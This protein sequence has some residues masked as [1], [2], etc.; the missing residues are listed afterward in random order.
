MGVTEELMIFVGDRL[1]EASQARVSVLDA[2]FQSGDAVWEGMRVYNGT[3]LKLDRHLSRLESSAR[4]LRIGLPYDRAGL[5]AAVYDTL[6]ANDFV[7]DTH[8]RLMVTRGARRTSGMDP[9]NAQGQG[10]LVII[11]ECKPV[12]AEPEPQRLR[13]ASTRRPQ[14][15]VL[16]PT[17]HHA[18]QLNSILARLEIVDDPQIDAALMLDTLGFVAEADTANIFSVKDGVVR[19]PSATA[20]LRGITR[21]CVLDLSRGAGY[22]TEETQLNL[23]DLYT[24]DE[25][26][27]TGTVCELV[28]VVALD[29]RRIG[30]GAPGPVWRDLLQRYRD[31]V[32]AETR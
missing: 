22:P 31:M 16:D 17:I 6:R 27:L 24:S 25:L 4:A 28:P 5:A 20:C 15:Q 13:T 29:S 7:D 2:G 18:N 12:S 11:A 26:F 23:Y 19:T 8:I 1:V 30:S 21:G 9:A 3:V 32:E 14:P 10:F